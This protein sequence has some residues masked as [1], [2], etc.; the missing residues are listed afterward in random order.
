MDLRA[1]IQERAELVAEGT[2][3]VETAIQEEREF[4]EEQ[5]AR[6]ETIVAR[7]AS[8]DV[9]MFP[10]TSSAVTTSTSPGP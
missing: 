7:I 8:L 4:N 9:G 6:D 2:L 3:A 1:L 5:V 10:A